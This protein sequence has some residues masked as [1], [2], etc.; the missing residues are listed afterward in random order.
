MK[1]T[2]SHMQA[3][4]R[5]TFMSPKDMVRHAVLI[6]ALYAAVHLLGLREFTTIICGTVA[7]PALGVRLCTLL[8]LGYMALYFGTVVLVPILM[9]AAAL[10]KLWEAMGRRRAHES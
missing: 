9:I 2:L 10:L 5:A 7:S 8:G 4:I 1:K 3:L 6:V